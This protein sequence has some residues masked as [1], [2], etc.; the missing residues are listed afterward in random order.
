MHLRECARLYNAALQERREAYAI[1][2]KSIGYAAQ[3]KMFTQVRKEG[4]TGIVNSNVGQ[5]VLR[6]VDRAFQ[7]FFRR[8][9]AG[10]KPGHPKFRSGKFYDS[11]TYSWNNG[12]KFHGSRLYAQGIGDLKI[13]LDRPIAG[14]IKTLTLKRE[15]AQWYALFSCEVDIEPLPISK[16]VVGI[17]MG[18]KSFL[19]T[20]EGD[21]VQN[22]KFFK[23][24]EAKLRMAQ[25]KLSRRKK[26]SLGWKAA[27]DEVGRI[28][29]KIKNQ[30][31]EFQHLI[32]KQIVDTNGLI[33]VEDLNI[34]GLHRGMLGKS[35]ADASWGSFLFQLDYKSQAAG[36]AFVKVDP[37]GTS[38]TCICG[39]SVP[40]ALGDR[41][42]LCDACNAVEDRDVM[43][44]RV[45]LQ[46]ALSGRDT[47]TT[48]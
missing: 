30:R 37:R 26:G 17:D 40:K 35:F 42:H 45:I 10:E 36:R 46:R 5:E 41:L 23:E 33:A 15:G 14:K 31:R 24:S 2:R 16:S 43:S 7:A 9:K 29:A 8:C 25:R 39:N 18:L 20:S 21:I 27:K 3:N 13:R 6:R 28:Q 32:S 44:A 47:T 48:R 11:F 19:A 38:Q 4:L 1:Q 12:C 22:P 34:K